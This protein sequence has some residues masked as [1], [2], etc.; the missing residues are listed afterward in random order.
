MGVSLEAYRAAIGL[1]NLHIPL[2]KQICL[3]MPLIYIIPLSLFLCFAILLI[4]SGNIESNP[5]PKTLCLSLAHLN[6]RSLNISDKFSEI[7]ALILLHNFDI[8]GVS[9]TWLNHKISDDQIHIPGYSLPHRLDRVNRPGG[10]VALFISEHLYSRRRRDL[11]SADLEL[12]LVEVTLNKAKFLCGVGYRPPDNSAEAVN[13]F[14]IDLQET[15]DKIRLEQYTALFLMGDFNAHIDLEE[16]ASGSD[17]GIRLY[18]FLQCNNLFQL[19]NEP[20]RITAHSATL[21][22]LIISDSPGYFTT[23]GT[24]SPPANCDHSIVFGRINIDLHKPRAFKRIVWDFKNTDV[25]A[26][27][28]ELVATF[29]N[30]TLSEEL[31][32]DVSYDHWFNLFLA[33]VKTH[34]PCRCVTVRPSDK[35][36][37]SNHIKCGIRK[38]DRLLKSYTRNKTSDNWEKYRRQRNH[39]TTCIRD[40]KQLYA[41]KLN[42]KLRNRET[43]AKTWWKTAKSLYG[44]K[45]ISSIPPLLVDGKII[46]E[47]KAKAELFN[48]YFISQTAIPSHISQVPHLDRFCSDSLSSIVVTEEQIYRLLECVDTTKACGFDGVSNKIIKL[49]AKGIS[50]PFTALVNLSLSLGQYP[51]NW[52]QANVIP[53]FKKVDRQLKENYRPVALLPSLSKICE[54]VVFIHLYD[55]LLRIGYLNPFQSGFRPGDSTVFQLIHMIHKI[56]TAL[57]H[58]KEVRMV[59]L[60]ISKAFDK[61]WHDALLC[62]LKHIG[63]EGS[64]YS[65]LASYLSNRKQRVVISS[66]SSEWKSVNAG[67]PQGSVLGPLLFLIYIND[68]TDGVSSD[69]YLYADDTSLLKVIDLNPVSAASELN[70]DLEKIALWSNKYLVTMNASKLKTLLFSTKR[71]TA[72][73]PPLI[74]DNKIIEEVES[75][76]HLGIT[77]TKSLSWRTHILTIH[78]KASKKLNLLKGLKFKVDRPTLDV[79]YKSIVRPL[80][81]YADAVWSGCTTGESELL[82]SLQY[83]AAKLVTGA[84]KGTSQVRLLDELAWEK[85]ALRRNFHRTTIFYKIMN[86]LTPSY[87]SALRPGQVFSRTQYNLRS[88]HNVSL[89]PVRTERFK[90]SF[91]PYSI[92]AWNE[93]PI[94]A[95]NIESLIRFKR[96]LKDILFKRKHNPLFEL[97]NRRTSVL[98]ARLRLNNSALNSNLFIRNCIPSP[99]CACGAPLESLTHYFLTCPKYAAQRQILLTSAVHILGVTWLSMSNTTK[100]NILLYGDARLN[101]QEN[102]ELFQAIHVYISSTERFS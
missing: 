63:I 89:L 39:I 93:L 60:D 77:L 82:E 23:T 16:P 17:I 33:I 66:I 48:E 43:N 65:W 50:Q 68:I 38:R 34:I 22:D 81:E 87:L 14:F 54:K 83:E 53:L 19:I 96:R 21:L 55:Y 59:F 51:T 31:N 94:S 4:I 85:L 88:S 64:L 18:H 37:M 45:L 67:V 10:G 29:R 78:Q 3:S 79:L 2:L 7:S 9:E 24:L 101:F 95:R 25:I 73:H 90:K 72:Y 36:W 46:S 84:M 42:E 27:N 1:F 26:L 71:S 62:K 15:I 80:M 13:N 98:H 11:E 30:L 32:I 12:V 75:H 52:K 61:V 41:T 69:I 70:T 8:F 6:A 97:G 28:N 92:K 49:C 56:Y 58:G 76:S 86:N 74:F 100:L 40:A 91:F 20:T 99:S 35:P 102:K 5:G 47:P 44:N 57:E